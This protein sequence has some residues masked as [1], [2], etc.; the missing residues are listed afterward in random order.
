M[1]LVELLLCCVVLTA[2]LSALVATANAVRTTFA[3]EQTRDTLRRLRLALNQYHSDTGQW[4]GGDTDTALLNLMQHTGAARL[5]KD[6]P[7][8]TDGQRYARVLD[9]YGEVIRFKAAASDLFGRPDFVSAG[10]DG[11]FGDPASPDTDIAAM[12][13]DNIYGSDTE[14]ATP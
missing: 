7:I 1:T 12:A 13:S 14:G 3:D 4:P 5:L 11:F 8:N 2:G 9:G 6:V 10:P